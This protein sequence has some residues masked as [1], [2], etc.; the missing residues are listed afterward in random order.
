MPKH[1]DRGARATPPIPGVN[2]IPPTARKSWRER[3]GALRNLPPFFRLIW[4]TSPLY[5]VTTLV[6]RLARGLLPVATLFVGKLII[7]EVLRLAGIPDAPGTLRA[8]LSSG[9]LSGLAWLLALELGLA[10]LSDARGRLV[11][12]VDA[13]LSEQFTNATSVRLMA[14][15]WTTALLLALGAC[16]TRSATVETDLPGTAWVPPAP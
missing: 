16:G 14:S 6:L 7:D 8:W 5:T 13:L 3:L 9:L 1:Y 2:G 10:V 11:S 12:L 4:D 15:G